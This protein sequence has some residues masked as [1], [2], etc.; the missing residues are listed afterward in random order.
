M[1]NKYNLFWA[2]I[3]TGAM[4]PIILTNKINKCNL[5]NDFLSDSIIIDTLKKDTLNLPNSIPLFAYSP[6]ELSKF[7]SWIDSTL[8][9]SARNNSNSIII[10]KTENKLYLIKKGKVCSEYAVDLGRNPLN[11][12]K[13]GD[14]CTPEGRYIVNKK[15][16]SNSTQFYKAFLI[17]YPNKEDKKSGKTGHSIEI[18]GEG[19]KGFNWTEGCGAVSNKDMDTLFNN[20][21]EKDLVT[22]VNY[23]SR[24]KLFY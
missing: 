6:E 14:L 20:I 17:N 12:Q 7:N 1:K 9:E 10:N 2:F 15:L 22:I 19:G 13:E 3:T 21:K 4:L 16:N 23:A 11:K 24:E 18:H 5:D 8:V